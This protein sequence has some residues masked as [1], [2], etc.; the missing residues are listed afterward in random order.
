MKK[1]TLIISVCL[2]IIFIA[3]LIFFNYS[4]KKNVTPNN[5]SDAALSKCTATLDNLVASVSSVSSA[6]ASSTV[7]H[8]AKPLKLELMTPEEKASFHLATNT[9]QRIQ[10][11]ERDA[12]GKITVYRL[13]K[14]D[15]DILKEY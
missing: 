6:I 10:V 7:P 1:A 4:V 3:L 15:S 2:N 9:A 14:K 5:N 8:V 12:N 13:I 11:L